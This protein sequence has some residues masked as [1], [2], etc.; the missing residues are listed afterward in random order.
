MPLPLMLYAVGL[1]RPEDARLL[2]SGGTDFLFEK[3]IA[4]KSKG[5]KSLPSEINER[6]VPGNQTTL[7]DR[8]LF[9]R[10]MECL[11]FRERALPPSQIPT[12][13][14]GISETE[15]ATPTTDDVQAVLDSIVSVQL[16]LAKQVRCHLP[17]LLA[18]PIDKFSFQ[19]QLK[20]GGLV[21]TLAKKR[22]ILNRLLENLS[23]SSPGSTKAQGP[24]E[25]S[26]RSGA[27]NSNT[28]SKSGKL[29][30]LLW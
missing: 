26:S 23:R 28:S 2:A 20:Q 27:L 5:G 22:F 13:Q 11:A 14:D 1:W 21:T 25:S 8:H 29:K 19:L 6:S 18:Q 4:K 17:P 16:D 9:D 7:A 15:Q 24:V 30:I 10:H 3:W 12:V